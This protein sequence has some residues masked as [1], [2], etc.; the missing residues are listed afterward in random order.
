[1][2]RASQNCCASESDHRTLA[3]KWHTPGAFPVRV[4]SGEV[5]SPSPPRPVVGTTQAGEFVSDTAPL[6]VQQFA[7][8]LSIGKS[9]QHASAGA[10][11]VEDRADVL[12]EAG[13][14]FDVGNRRPSAFSGAPF[15][16]GEAS[17]FLTAPS[18]RT[19]RRPLGRGDKRPP[20]SGALLDH[21]SSSSR[22]DHSKTLLG[23][24]RRC[25]PTRNPFGPLPVVR[26]A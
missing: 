13:R 22:S 3:I 17:A 5:V 24:Q 12:V 21:C 18:P 19:S 8:G 25:L 11:R 4:S 1:M 2:R 10:G 15:L 20:A 23:C 14:F 16:R 9:S 6:G 7:P 26:Q